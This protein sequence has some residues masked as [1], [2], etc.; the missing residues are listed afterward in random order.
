MLMLHRIFS[1]RMIAVFVILAV[2]ILCA[3]QARAQVAGATLSGTVTDPSGA[4]IADAKVTILNK[5]TGQMREATAGSGGFYSVPNL[6]PGV[7]DI[8][9]TAAGFSA[10]KQSDITLTVGAQQ[11]LNVA[12]KIG[13]AN[14]TVEVTAAAPMVQLGSSTL[15]N[16]VEA[17]TVRELPLNGRDW[18]SLATLEPG[19]AQVRTHPL[20]TTQGSRGLGMQMTIGGNRPTQ[21]SFRLDGALVNDFSNAG[22]G[23]VLG[24]NL[25]VDSI[26]E[27]NVL[28]SNYSAEYGFTSGGVIN[29]V[30]RSGTNAFHGSAFDFF[31][32]DK[33][34]ASNFFNNANGLPKNPLKRNQFGGSA[35][36][37]ILK[38]KLFIFGDYEGVRQS[39]GTAMPQFTISQAV[40]AGRVT[41]LQNGVVSTVAIDPNIQ[42]YLALFPVANGP[43][44]GVGENPNV[45]QFNWTS[46]QTANE[47]FYT[48]R[49]DYKVSDK[50]S[51]FATYVRDPSTIHIPTSFDTSLSRTDAYRT[52]GVVEETHI[53]SAFAAN[54]V[55]VAMDRTYGLT[56]H[57]DSSSAINPVANDPS[58]AMN[59]ASSARAPQVSLSNTNITLAPGGLHSGTLQDLWNQI[60][61]VYDDAFITRGNHGL[62]FGFSF[63]AQ[64]NDV[65][66]V[67]N[68]N[69]NATF[70]NLATTIAK[71]DC[72]QSNG[73]INGSCGALVNFLAD[74]PRTVTPPADLVRS[75]KHYLRDKVFGGYIQ[76]DW[77][78]RPNLTLNLGIRYE[79]QTNPTEKNGEVAFLRTLKSPST[80]LVNYFY[81]SNPTLKN[82]E[83]RVGFAWDP[84]GNGKTAVRGG[85]GIFDVLPAPY[86]LQLYAATTAP[87][88]TTLGVV[89]PPNTPSPAAGIFPN[90]IPALAVNGTP[91]SRV[92]AYVDGANIKRNY[93]YQ[94]N[95][96][97]QRQLTPSMTLLLGYTGSRG[98]RNPLLTEGGNSV[99]PV[100]LNN[101]PAG[102]GF[103]WPIPYTLD[104]KIGAGNNALY[105]PNVGIIRSIFWL[106]QSYY[107]GLQVKL[108][109]RMSHGFQ[110]TGSFTWSKSI[111]D[112]SGSAA[113]DT[114]TNEWN[115]P[116]WYNLGMDRGL[117]AF[118]VGRNLVIN[119]LW[120]PTPP[121][122]LGALG[123]HVLGGWQLG[124]IASVADGIPMTPSIGMNGSD[125]LGEIYTTIAPPQF[126][127]SATCNS[128]ASVVNP[129]NP[130]H[131][132][133]P[134]CL[135]LVPQTAV[136]TPYCDTARATS[137]G[138][139]GTCP[140][141]RGNL[142]RNMIIGPGLF[143]LDFS[144]VKNNYIPK[145]SESFN[146]QFRAEFFNSLNRA[147]FQSPTLAANQGGGALQVIDSSGARNGAFGQ[148]T[149]T[150]TPARQI[151]FALKVIW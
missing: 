16:E 72:T 147:N 133:R 83:P 35:G 102:V 107:N 101:A 116:I 45:G 4:A 32:N 149:L 86:I 5:A 138:I 64:H 15:S 94:W 7:Y 119:G 130:N 117:S 62:K 48:F 141:I 97:I 93:V 124:A 74:L 123:N 121:K 28:T 82:F 23:S 9:I 27:F 76:D 42:K 103:Y 104:P 84:F 36:W 127:K 63:L 87:F 137:L 52:L 26:Q 68:Y 3:S 150:Q 142:A 92:W 129:G 128:F 55:R 43:G 19:V 49:G 39:F 131:Y 110:A 120:A 140:N 77:R 145:I 44:N 8:T 59:P 58:L 66:A 75:N 111:D 18:A 50:D 112:T 46:V 71:A 14:Q 33:L 125:L 41:N 96:N 73:A 51:V 126:L 144:V 24:Q 122:T 118:D 88:I 105:N 108:D 54:T 114:Y 151:Q 40:R 1:H 31:Q 67:N 132:L 34:N 10:S 60:F 148:I 79:M 20:G 91:Q 99:Q 38:D 70:T 2:A 90:G 98:H 37:R 109:K 6:L 30:T 100:D 13:E 11:V 106:S 139:P 57:Y 81:A 113:A 22:P 78:I 146:V 95:F 69:G 135:G 143:N 89:G 56:N 29:A 21:N 80:D 53:F 25:G 65:I 61:Q 85:F 17:A 47:N 12:L 115:A 134:E 136:N